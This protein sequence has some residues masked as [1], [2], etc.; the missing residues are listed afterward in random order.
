MKQTPLEKINQRRRQ[1]HVHS[2]IYYHMNT[3]IIDDATFDKWS[4]ELVA[5]HKKH[6]KLVNQGYRPELFNDWTGDTGMHLPNDYETGRLARTL[7]DQ[8]LDETKTVG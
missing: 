6:P 1:I 4:N 5:L 8:H 3:S 7:I 2:V